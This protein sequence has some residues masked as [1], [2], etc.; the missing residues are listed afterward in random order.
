MPSDQNWSMQLET[1]CK[2]LGHDTK[3]LEAGKLAIMHGGYHCH[4]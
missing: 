3:N 2:G 1:E 4:S